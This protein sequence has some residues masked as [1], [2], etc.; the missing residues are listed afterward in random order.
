MKNVLEETAYVTQHVYN[1]LCTNSGMRAAQNHRKIIGAN[2]HV[3]MDMRSVR[4]YVLC[5]EF[6]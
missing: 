5:C 4:I 3:Y 2:L 1:V 6:A